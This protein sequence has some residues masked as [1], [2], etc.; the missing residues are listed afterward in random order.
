MIVTITRQVYVHLLGEVNVSE[1]SSA[2]N[3]LGNPAPLQFI[4]ELNSALNTHSPWGQSPLAQY[5]DTQ[6]PQWSEIP[7]FPALQ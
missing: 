3:S 2:V 6:T 4:I 1:L 5:H 7:Q